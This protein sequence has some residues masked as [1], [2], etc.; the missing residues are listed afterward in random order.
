MDALRELLHKQ[1]RRAGERL[2]AQTGISAERL[3]ELRQS[4]Q[5]S[6]DELRRIAGFFRVELRDLLP[7]HPRFQSFGLLFRSGGNPIDEITS[8]ALSRR[9]GYSIELLSTP[10]GADFSWLGKF[11]KGIGSYS[12]AENNAELF[13]TLFVGDNQVGPLLNL[14]DIAVNKMGILLFVV[15]SSRFEG[16]S[17]Y[18][19]GAPFIFL[20]D[21]FG[22]RMLFTL[23]HEMGHVVGHHGN[24]TRDFAIVDADTERRPQLHKNAAEFYAH[25]FASCLLLPRRGIGIALRKIRQLHQEPNKELGDLEILLLSRIYGVS[26][27]VA[28][29]RCE[30]LS[31][32]PRGGAASLNQALDEKYGSPEKRATA[33]HLPPRPEVLFPRLPSRLLNAAVEKIRTGEI[34]IG[35]AS[36]ILGLSIADLMTVN[37]SRAN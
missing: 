5:P 1:N 24:S 18:V 27:Y 15:P 11:R 22:P 32:L 17:A 23:A 29:K 25:A 36:S 35:K 16:A 13:R 14:P 20:A 37:A 31:L 9:I 34:S 12:D 7:A 3:E 8:S 21:R 28:A 33:A 6:L 4:A 26:F 10:G 2:T 19:E 30:D